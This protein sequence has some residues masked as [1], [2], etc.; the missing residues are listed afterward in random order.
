MSQRILAIDG[1]TKNTGLAIFNGTKLVHYESIT[2]SGELLSR[3]LKMVN[4]IKQLYEEYQITDVVMEQIL[5]QEVSHNQNTY[6]A[7]MYLQAATALALYKYKQSIVFY[8]ASH[9]RKICGIKTSRYIKRQQLKQQSQMLVKTNYGIDVN[10]D[11]SD[12]ILLGYAYI[13]EHGSAF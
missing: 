13:Q 10:D 12:A 8:V 11:I 4:R 6:K 5:P 2:A 1:S 3:I 7:L 9:W